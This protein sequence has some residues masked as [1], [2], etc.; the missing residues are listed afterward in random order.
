M[1][2]CAVPGDVAALL[3]HSREKSPR[4]R[5]ATLPSR[6][7]RAGRAAAHVVPAP[8]EKGTK[9]AAHEAGASGDQHPVALHPGL[10]FGLGL[11]VA[12]RLDAHLPPLTVCTRGYCTAGPEGR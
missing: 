11:A 3:R 5:H 12:V 4:R 2:A 1:P 10:G 8:H 6:V 9:V 7:R